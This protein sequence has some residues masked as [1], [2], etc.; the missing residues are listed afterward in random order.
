MKINFVVILVTCASKK[1]AEGVA[2]S[3]L[4]KR[5]I[6]CANIISG[7]QS[8]FWW[9]GRIDKAKE[10]LIII[11]AKAS[12]FKIIEKEVKR[13]HSYKVA[14]IIALPIVKGSRDYLKW[15]EAVE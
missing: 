13:V 9:H 12:N 5:L 8:K 7:V 10:V 15:I 6:A 11:K 2:G 14:E 4:K 1:E 3:L